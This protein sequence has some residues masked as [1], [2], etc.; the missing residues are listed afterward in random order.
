MN[1]DEIKQNFAKNIIRLRKSHHL[2][3]TELGEELHYSSKAIS[4]WENGETIPD[5][6]GLSAIADYFD[7]TIDELISD[8]KAV[9]RSFTIRNRF[10]I[11]LSSCLLPYLIALVIFT[12]LYVKGINLSYVAFAFG[13]IASA[14]TGIVLTRIWYSRRAVF[15]F[16]TYLVVASIITI[17]LMLN[18]SYWW[19]VL[20]IGVVTEL[21]LFVFFKI[22]FPSQDKNLQ[23]KK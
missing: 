6:D 17:I 14:I 2:N 20:T 15:A 7:V 10:Y 23:I 19:L 18:F 21:I 12:F 22:H 3:Q 1:I 16:I 9:N 8:S 4:K 13:G 5:I 11:T